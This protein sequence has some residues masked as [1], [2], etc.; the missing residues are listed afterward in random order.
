[1]EVKLLAL[2]VLLFVGC[3]AVKEKLDEDLY[4]DLLNSKLLQQIEKRLMEWDQDEAS[5]EEQ[6]V[7]EQDTHADGITC[8]F[9]MEENTIIR[10]RD[11]LNAGATYVSAPN[12]TSREGCRSQC[13]KLGT[14]CNQAV[15]KDK[16]KCW[17]RL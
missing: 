6:E 1:M 14:K 11:S 3:V 8:H 15:F 17:Q 5:T 12:V 4:S 2:I 13:C 16:V 10:T 9:K 7:S